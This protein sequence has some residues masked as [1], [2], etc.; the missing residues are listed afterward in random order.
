MNESGAV[1]SQCRKWRYALWRVWGDPRRMCLFVGL[2]PSA[3]DEMNDDATIRRCIGFARKWGFG[4]VYIVNLF[5]WRARYPRDLKMV[6][7]PVGG[8][9][10]ENIKKYVERSESIVLAWGVHGDYRGRAIEVLESGALGSEL[11]C[12]GM[13]KGGHPCHPL[14]L[15]VSTEME[16]Y[17][18]TCSSG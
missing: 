14:Y 5:A 12:L 4:G 17:L 18:Q 2:N 1:F 3:A 6:S 9:N 8:E 7:D 10:D 11:Y 16:R 13:T 15:P